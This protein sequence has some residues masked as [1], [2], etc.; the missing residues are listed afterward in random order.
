MQ[1]VCCAEFQRPE[2]EAQEVFQRKKVKEVGREEGKRIF[3]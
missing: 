3:K 1:L 2:G